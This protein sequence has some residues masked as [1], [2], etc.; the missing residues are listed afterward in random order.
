MSA[1]SLSVNTI[2]RIGDV[3]E[4]HTSDQLVLLD[5]KSGK[6]LTLSEVGSYVWG[7]IDGARTIGDI[8]YSVSLEFDVENEQALVDLIQFAEQLV[9]AGL[10]YT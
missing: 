2:L 4:A 3:L 6:F 9:D 5:Q 8:A 1:S 10:V 7:L